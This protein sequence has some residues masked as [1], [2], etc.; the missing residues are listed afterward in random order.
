MSSLIR[1]TNWSIAKDFSGKPKHS[2][3]G[4]DISISDGGV[5]FRRGG[6]DIKAANGLVVPSGGTPPPQTNAYSD[7]IGKVL[8]VFVNTA[9]AKKYNTFDE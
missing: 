1:G 9:V 5:Y 7:D 4:V 6:K 2:Q 3:G 8:K